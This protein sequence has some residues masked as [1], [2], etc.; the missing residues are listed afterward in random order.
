M[1]VSVCVCVLFF[2]SLSSFPFFYPSPP[3]MCSPFPPHYPTSS[4]LSII[5][6]PPQYLFSYH[7]LSSIFP[8]FSISSNSSSSL[9]TRSFSTSNISTSLHLHF[10]LV[11][12]FD[13]LLKPSH[14]VPG[15]TIQ[16]NGPHLCYLSISSSLLCLPLTPPPAPPPRSFL[17][18]NLSHSF[19]S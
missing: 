2:L 19:P 18:C 1:K 13:L 9:S 8:A 10:L 17:P 14:A 6:L 4:S 3:P 7:L 12:L 5:P 11:L 16:S 15:H